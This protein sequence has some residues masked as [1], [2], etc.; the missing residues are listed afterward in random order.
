MVGDILAEPFTKADDD[1]VFYDL[2]DPANP[3][4]I[5]AVALDGD[6]ESGLSTAAVAQMSDGSFILAG[7]GEHGNLDFY[8]ASNTPHVI[9]ASTS[10]SAIDQVIVPDEVPT[11][12]GYD[13]DVF[14][15][16]NFVTDC[17]TGKL[18]LV[19]TVNDEESSSFCGLG[20]PCYP[21]GFD[22]ATLYEVVIS[23]D[24]PGPGESVSLDP[25]AG[26][27]FFCNEEGV[28]TDHCNFD[29]AAGIY[30]DPNN[31]MILYATEH[32]SDGYRES[33]KMKEFRPVPHGNCLNSS[34]G[35]IE[36]YKSEQPGWDFG[37]LI[38][39]RTFTNAD[40]EDLHI[41]GW[42]DKARSVAWCI[43][44]G[45]SYILYEHKNPCEGRMVKLTGSGVF[46]QS[47]LSYMGGEASCLRLV[48]DAGLVYT[49]DPSL[50]HQWEYLLDEITIIGRNADSGNVAASA[51]TQGDRSIAVDIPPSALSDA[52]EITFQNVSP[53]TYDILD[54]VATSY[55]FSLSYQGDPLP[56]DFTFDLPVQVTITYADEDVVGMDEM[57]LF[58]YYWDTSLQSWTLAH[59]TCPGGAWPDMDYDKNQYRFGICKLGEYAFWGVTE[60]LK[61][62]VD[63]LH[64]NR[65]TLGYSRAQAIAVEEGPGAQ[66][67][68]Y[69]LGALDNAGGTLYD[70]ESVT[71]GTL[72]DGLLEDYDALLIPYYK[73]ALSVDEVSAVQRFVARGGGLI[74]SGD[75]GFNV[76]N[77]EL[78]AIYGVDFDPWCLFAPPPAYDPEL[79]LT[80]SSDREALYGVD[81]AVFHWSQG[82]SLYG[83]ADVLLVTDGA[84]WQ[85]Y[86]WSQDFDGAVDPVASFT[87][88]AANDTGCGRFIGLGDSHFSDA[89]L[90]WTENEDLMASLFRWAGSGTQCEVA[91][92]QVPARIL[93]DEGHD[94]QMTLDWARADELVAQWGAGWS[95]DEFMLEE[96]AGNLGGAYTFTRT[97]AAL[98]RDLL[99]GYDALILPPYSETLSGAEINAV[100]NFVDQG[101]GLMILGDAYFGM[102]NPELTTRYGFS[103]SPVGVFTGA[104]QE[105]VFEVP[106]IAEHASVAG[107]L[108]YTAAWGQSLVI[109]DAVNIMDTL[110]YDAW[111]DANGNDARDD[112]EQGRY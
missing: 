19:A 5:G 94:N 77:P 51:V 47:Q 88:G 10:W 66:P 25:V 8:R 40:Y 72:S 102:P 23:P 36:L 3:R 33:V 26:R 107:D 103:L 27:L 11:Y 97:T 34:D 100:V 7:Y 63:E 57:S 68:W 106:L 84:T 20:F 71:T 78:P 41:W 83:T 75:C 70:L 1:V 82:L 80:V 43:P 54:N 81:S 101:G 86:D 31:Q 99:A 9:N 45:Y 98:S 104:G 59:D 90:R 46:H 87:V 108:G 92:G 64:D 74:M 62:L 89:D 67:E 48:P 50:G 22:L 15:S 4:Y 91:N 85:D 12:G 56:D 79:N 13:W 35:W 112:G 30:V 14:Q 29:A 93:V 21:D 32:A 111:E 2:S 24:S 96:L 105:G 53:P 17:G 55:G 42:G 73:D 38:E 49:V 52:I 60:P 65:M 44:Q 18:Y 69:Y 28:G 76:P 16:L 39:N 61:V 37:K 109:S 110:S 6:S 95:A 58:P